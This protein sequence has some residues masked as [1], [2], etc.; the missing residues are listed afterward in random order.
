MS[1]KV[2]TAGEVLAAADVN[3]FLMDQTVMSFAGTAA[4]GSAIGTAT[5]GMTTYLEDSDSLEIYNG[6]SFAPALSIGAWAAFTPTWV[7]GLTVG[8]GVYNTSH[9]SRVGKTVNL[10]IDFTLGSTSSVTGDLVIDVP[11]A[12]ARKNT[13]NTGSMYVFYAQTGAGNWPGFPIASGSGS[14]RFLLRW[15]GT[16]AGTNPVAVGI[17]SVS[18]T[19]PFTWATGHRICFAATYEVA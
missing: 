8:N 6:T 16:A 2:F 15:I 17:A 3:S 18:A 10:A 13:F 14:A 4:R 1:R 5:E 7:G 12:I 19:T 11:A 9:F